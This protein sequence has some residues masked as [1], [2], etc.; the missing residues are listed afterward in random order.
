MLIDAVRSLGLADQTLLDIGG[1]VGVI[2]YELLRD[3]VTKIMHVEAS[4]AYY[5]VAKREAERRGVADRF[6]YFLGNFVDLSED[7][8][9]A[10]IVTLDR[11]ICCYHDVERLV[12]SST[13]LAKSAYALVYPRDAWWTKAFTRLQNLLFK[14]R[15]SLFRVYVH[16]IREVDSRIRKRGFQLLS[17]RKTLVW[18]VALYR[19]GP[20]R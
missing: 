11:V 16:P 8:P 13:K 3:G 4:R 14:W 18:E 12:D 9:A 17:L 6:H 7:I 20:T 5:A 1:G 15:G 2:S 10:D 19:R